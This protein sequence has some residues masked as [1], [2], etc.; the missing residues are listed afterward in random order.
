MNLISLASQPRLFKLVFE[1]AG[2]YQQ[3]IEELER[4]MKETYS[5]KLGII[6]AESNRLI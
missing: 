6:I 2:A 3:L 1:L 5:E 4:E